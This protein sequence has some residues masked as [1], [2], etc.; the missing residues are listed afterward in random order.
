MFVCILKYI[1]IFA[2]SKP[3][4]LNFVYSIRH[5]S[6]LNIV[7]QLSEKFNTRVNLASSNLI[8][9]AFRSFL[10]LSLVTHCREFTVLHSVCSSIFV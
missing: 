4:Y 7:F 5:L 2:N 10:F 1:Y 9:F 6:W 3:R 8:F